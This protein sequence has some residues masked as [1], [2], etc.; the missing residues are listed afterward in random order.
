[1]GPGFVADPGKLL[2]ALALRPGTVRGASFPSCASVVPSVSF[3]S[4]MCPPLIVRS[5]RPARPFRAP[6]PASLG[7]C[8]ANGEARAVNRHGPSP[9]VE[10]SVRLGS[11]RVLQAGSTRRV[12][13]GKKSIPQMLELVGA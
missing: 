6:S 4:S 13:F 10:R 5:V 12:E 7:P 1:M 9:F 3:S 8:D 11:A 2:A